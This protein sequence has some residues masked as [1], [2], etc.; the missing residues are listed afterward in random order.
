MSKAELRRE[1]DFGLENLEKVY[2]RIRQFAQQEIDAGV[3]TSALTY[4]CLGYY[5]A[6]EHLFIRI[7]KFQ[8]IGIPSGPFSHRDTLKTF[9]TFVNERLIIANAESLQIIENLM[10]FRHVA[11]KIYGFLIDATKLSF[12]I[13]DIEEY[14][15]RIKQLILDVVLSIEEG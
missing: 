1:I 6:I 5:N 4:E 8:R 2:A 3:K 15:D 7:L 13:R 12:V 10:A 11:T 9:E 14:H